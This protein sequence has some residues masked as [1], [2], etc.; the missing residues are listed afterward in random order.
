[1]TDA[2]KERLLRIADM[3][4][5]K[6][7]E[8]LVRALLAENAAQRERIAE[9]EAVQALNVSLAERVAAQSELLTK[10]AETCK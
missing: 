10:R 9:L 3:L 5:R 1:M 6:S 8:A 2:A 7:D 4:P